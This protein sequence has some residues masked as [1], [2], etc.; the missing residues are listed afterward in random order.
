MVPLGAGRG[1]LQERDTQTPD[2]SLPPKPAP[3]VQK[4]YESAPQVRDLR[5]EATQRFVPSVVKRKLD[6]TKGKGRLLEEEEIE[7]L[8]R[9][10]YGGAVS[11]GTADIAGR[12]SSE[13][14]GLVVNAAPAVDER[15]GEEGDSL[16]LGE[17]HRRRLE[18]E[19]RFARE[20]AMAAGE[21]DDAGN[22]MHKGVTMEEVDDEDL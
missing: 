18:E 21:Q 10:G 5:K 1:H 8:E 14:R 19:E 6:A 11:G 4:V 20:L 2:L 16:R 12:E 15:M 3:V 17:E 9:E 22:G 13:N 7:M